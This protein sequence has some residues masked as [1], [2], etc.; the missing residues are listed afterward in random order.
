TTR[1][2]IN[3]TSLSQQDDKFDDRNSKIVNTYSKSFSKNEAKYKASKSL[4]KLELSCVQKSRLSLGSPNTSKSN[5]NSKTISIPEPN[6]KKASKDIEIFFESP[7]SL[8]RSVLGKQ[9]KNSSDQLHY[10]KTHINL[11]PY[12]FGR[13]RS[14]STT[15][16]HSFNGSSTLRETQNQRKSTVKEERKYSLQR[17]NSFDNTSDNFKLLKNKRL[18]QNV[19]SD[20]KRIYSPVNDKI[21]LEETQGDSSLA[22]SLESAKPKER[23]EIEGHIEVMS[24]M[25]LFDKSN[26]DKS[27][28]SFRSSF[29]SLAEAN[30]FGSSESIQM[31][32]R[33]LK[34]HTPHKVDSNVNAQNT[35]CNLRLPSEIDSRPQSF[36]SLDKNDAR[37]SCLNDEFFEFP[38]S[39]NPKEKNSILVGMGND[40]DG[41]NQMGCYMPIESV[42]VQ[43]TRLIKCVI[44]VMFIAHLSACSIIVG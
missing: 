33:A 44:G 22:L 39:S 11:E 21:Q 2:R 29:G 20:L 24:N 17:E 42:P 7:S 16:I 4:K 36:I 15:D 41:F 10:K 31:F 34:R 3:T 27:D 26:L 35:K 14:S 28:P 30:M 38:I 12:N 13:V 19:K 40:R 25:N 9:F 32:R 37:K 8:S 43:V 6:K 23:K 5:I 1:Q 18:D